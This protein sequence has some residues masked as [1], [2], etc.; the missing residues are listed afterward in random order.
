MPAFYGTQVNHGVVVPLNAQSRGSH[1][2][3]VISKSDSNVLIVRDSLFERIEELESIGAVKLIV[4]VGSTPRVESMHEARV[5]GWADWLK[6][7][8]TTEFGELPGWTDS[9]VIQFTSGTTGRAKGVLFSHHYLY[10]AS[11]V[12]ADSLERTPEDI[13]LHQCPCSMLE[14]CIL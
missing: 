13:C 14:H 12:V 2:E 5:V 10:M 11:A 9:A 8:E 6:D 3:Y 1:L 7:S 4:V